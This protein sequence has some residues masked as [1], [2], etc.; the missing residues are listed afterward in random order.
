MQSDSSQ[1]VIS[2]GPESRV[3]DVTAPVVSSEGQW[4]CCI[5]VLVRCNCFYH[6]NRCVYFGASN[7]RTITVVTWRYLI[8]CDNILTVLSCTFCRA[9]EAFTPER[10]W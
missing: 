9:S 8:T 5:N 1:P 4:G 6:N 7:P 2:D 3:G 10:H